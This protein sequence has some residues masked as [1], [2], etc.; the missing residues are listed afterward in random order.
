MRRPAGGFHRGG[1]LDQRP[2]G[3]RNQ[4][5]G[6]A[7]RSPCFAYWELIKYAE[8]A[9]LAHTAGEIAQY[10]DAFGGEYPV[11]SAIVRGQ[12]SNPTLPAGFSG[13]TTLSV[14]TGATKFPNII[15]YIK[16][17]VLNV[18]N[19]KGEEPKSGLLLWANQTYPTYTNP[20]TAS[21]FDVDHFYYLNKLEED[22]YF[23]SGPD[24]VRE[25]H[26]DGETLPDVTTSIRDGNIGVDFK[27]EEG[28]VE[29]PPA[30]KTDDGG[31]LAASAAFTGSVCW[32]FDDGRA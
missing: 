25:I 2:L 12:F 24:A 30:C 17:D 10:V 11:M 5:S 6:S 27:A 3:R 14:S 20:A 4:G 8:Y 22:D 21:G 28:E 23:A 9:H 19:S 32:V 31:G 29:A 7:L 15:F 13:P 26:E 1:S 16:R 18:L